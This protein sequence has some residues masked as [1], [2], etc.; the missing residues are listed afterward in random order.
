MTCVECK[1]DV[2]TQNL[3]CNRYN[4]E[5]ASL[6]CL[7]WGGREFTSLKKNLLQNILFL[8]VWIFWILCS[9]LGNNR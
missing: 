5:A 2:T 3:K 9:I 7:I 6:T 4:M 1:H 8:F